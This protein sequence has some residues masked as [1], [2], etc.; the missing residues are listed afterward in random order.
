MLLSFQIVDELKEDVGDSVSHQ[1]FLQVRSKLVSL[2]QL[3]LDKKLKNSNG[4]TL[5]LPT[6]PENYLSYCELVEVAANSDTKNWF[7]FVLQNLN[8]DEN[9]HTAEGEVPLINIRKLV[10]KRLSKNHETS[11]QMEIKALEDIELVMLRIATTNKTKNKEKDRFRLLTAKP[12]FLAYFPREDY[13][14][15]NSANP[16]EEHCEALV[17]SLKCTAYEG[18]P[19][20]GKHLESLRQLRCHRDEPE[21]INH[22]IWADDNEEMPMLNEFS[23]SAKNSIK[24]SLLNLFAQNF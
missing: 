2:I 4:D 15:A 13:F 12:T 11:V 17:A 8:K 24:V 16:N 1:M 9:F 21:E 3:A 14:Y 10:K 5:S 7:T 18:I 22:D 20:N 23:V 19:L 6:D